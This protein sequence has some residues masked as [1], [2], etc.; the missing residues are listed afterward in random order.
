MN[1]FI[2]SFLNE[3]NWQPL[4]LVVDDDAISLEIVSENLKQYC[5]VIKCEN[6]ESALLTAISH[7]PDL[8]ILDYE[9]PGLS[10]PELCKQIKSHDS[11][12]DVPVIFMTANSDAKSQITCWDSG[13]VDFIIKPFIAKT[14]EKR[15]QTHLKIKRLTDELAKLAVTDGLTKTYNRRF[16]K[17]FLEEQNKLAARHNDDFTLAIVDIDFF[18]NYNDTYGHL[19][20]DNCLRKV[21]DVINSCIL[22]QSDFVARYG[23]E[24]FVI[25]MPSTSHDGALKITETIHHKLAE[26]NI[27]HASSPFGKVTVSIGCVTQSA[28]SIPGNL[29]EDADKLLYRAKELGRDQTQFGE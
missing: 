11:L 17:G 24:E 25:V 18:K 1:K 3:N 15:I 7:H 8:I 28:P 4:V 16:L 13:C 20:G 22:R 6:S 23:G 10:G 5:N 27:H 21:A 14:L 9:M 29:L 2:K 26:Q 12:E 19:A